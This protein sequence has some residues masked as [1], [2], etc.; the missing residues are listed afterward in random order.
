MDHRQHD[1]KADEDGEERDEVAQFESVDPQ[2]FP[3]GHGFTSD[4]NA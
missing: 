4:G 1:L 3:E 2:L